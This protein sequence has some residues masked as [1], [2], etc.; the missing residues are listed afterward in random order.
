MSP[1]PITLDLALDDIELA[2]RIASGDNVAFETVMRRHNGT[3]FRVARSI[4]KDDH[5]AEDAL[6]EA[7]VDAYRQIAKFRGDAKL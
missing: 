7:Y 2:R 6:Q 1:Q 3:L 5:E 4:L